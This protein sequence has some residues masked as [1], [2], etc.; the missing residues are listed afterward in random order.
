MGTVAF[1]TPLRESHAHRQCSWGDSKLAGL[2]RLLHQARSGK[3]TPGRSA[4][5]HSEDPEVGP[6]ARGNWIDG[7][8]GAEELPECDA[9]RFRTWHGRPSVRAGAA[10]ARRS[11]V[12]ARSRAFVP[13]S[14]KVSACS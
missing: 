4:R 2:L 12:A 1:E 7:G 3:L 9:G 6:A 10:Q 5:P 13:A 14:W 11:S 8:V